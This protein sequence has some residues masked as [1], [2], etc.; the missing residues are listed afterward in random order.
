MP[1]DEAKLRHTLARF[2][3]ME[4]HKVRGEHLAAV[5]RHLRLGRFDPFMS[6]TVMPVFGGMNSLREVVEDRTP[7][8]LL[9]R[10]GAGSSTAPRNR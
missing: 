5:E 3:E 10:H 6:D 1:D 7:R 2:L 9:R 4:G 8:R